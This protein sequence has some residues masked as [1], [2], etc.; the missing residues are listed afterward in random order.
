MNKRFNTMKTLLHWRPCRSALGLF[1]P[2]LPMLVLFAATANGFAATRFVWQDSPC[3]GPPY[4]NWASIA[5]TIQECI[6]A[7][8]AGDEIVV[9]NGV[10]ATGTE[11]KPGGGATV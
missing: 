5:V 4:A 6:D 9:T 2:P 11:H 8:A 1:L 7:A 10:Y 3:P